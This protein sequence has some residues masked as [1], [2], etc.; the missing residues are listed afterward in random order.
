MG[1]SWGVQHLDT[2]EV[3]TKL[4]AA[5]DQSQVRK[6]TMSSASSSILMRNECYLS[7]SETGSVSKRSVLSGA[8]VI[9][10][11]ATFA[12]EE[13]LILSPETF[14]YVITSFSKTN[15]R[16]VGLFKFQLFFAAS[17]KKNP[18]TC[19]L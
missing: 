19:P 4:C 7:L 12:R 3:V 14:L 8:H 11:F 10:H 16:N 17:Q 5:V 9:Y 15:I 6:H 18:P 1:C 2:S 13:P